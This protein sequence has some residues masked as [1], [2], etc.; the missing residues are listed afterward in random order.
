MNLSSL[1][2]DSFFF[3]STIY[4]NLINNGLVYKKKRLD[5]IITFKKKIYIMI[6]EYQKK[7]TIFIYKLLNLKLIKKNK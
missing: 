3:R 4:Y 6:F 7:M 5:R 2:S 1:I